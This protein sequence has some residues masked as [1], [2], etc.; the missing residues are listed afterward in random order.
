[1]ILK[2]SFENEIEGENDKRL[3]MYQYEGDCGHRQRI[4]YGK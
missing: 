4:R 1:M 2:S 3:S